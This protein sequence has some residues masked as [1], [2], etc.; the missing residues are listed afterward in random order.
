VQ[1]AEICDSLLS[2]GEHVGLELDHPVG[3]HNGIVE[4][5]TY[6]SCPPLHGEAR[7]GSVIMVL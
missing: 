1:T 2:A 4:E 7:K 6:F 5:I 3:K